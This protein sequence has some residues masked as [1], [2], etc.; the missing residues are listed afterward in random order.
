MLSFW[1]AVLSVAVAACVI[2]RGRKAGNK[3]TPRAT[4]RDRAAG[5]RVPVFFVTPIRTIRGDRYCAWIG[6]V[7][8]VAE[9]CVRDAIYE[10]G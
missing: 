3:V 9:D 8:E 7:L 2:R 1:L 4:R 5:T 10:K 6:A